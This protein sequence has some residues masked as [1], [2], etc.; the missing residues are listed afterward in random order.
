MAN[1]TEKQKRFVSEYLIDLNATQAAIRAGYS[2]KSA[3]RIAVELLNKTQVAAE[4][5]KRQTRLQNKLEITQ[6]KVLQ[7][8]AAIAFASG[9]DFAEVRKNGSVKIIPTEELPQDKRKAIASIKK[10]RYGTEVSTYD[11]VRALEM[12]GKHLG[13]FER[14]NGAVIEQENNLFEVIKQSTGE[15]IDTSEIPEIEP[16]AAAGNDMVEPPEV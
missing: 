13:M 4:V 3:S 11:K 9:A 15:E 14:D 1:L 12:L 8:L 2:E 16:E 5:R 6:E 7:E 10:G